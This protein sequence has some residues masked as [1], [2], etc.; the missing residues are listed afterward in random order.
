MTVNKY[1]TSSTYK[2]IYYLELIGFYEILFNTL[3]GANELV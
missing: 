2:Y 1:R 3:R